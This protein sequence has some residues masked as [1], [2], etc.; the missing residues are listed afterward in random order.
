MKFSKF[1]ARCNRKVLIAVAAGAALVQ[2]NFSGCDQSLRNSL[3]D[4]VETALVGLV[5]TIISAFFTALQ[6]DG[7]A[8]SQPVVQ[9]ITDLV[10]KLA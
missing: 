3:L 6:N 10:S 9:A 4:G 2:L 8:G 5:S 1:L 7:S